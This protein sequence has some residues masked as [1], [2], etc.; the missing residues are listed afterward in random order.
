MARA[1]APPPYL[2]PGRPGRRGLRPPARLPCHWLPE[3]SVCSAPSPR[4]VL[5]EKPQSRGSG[6][7]REHG[8]AQSAQGS[9]NVPEHGSPRRLLG[10]AG[11]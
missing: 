5:P 3:L 7:A 9:G 4:Q 10:P 8:G 1:S 11:C 6:A 2:T